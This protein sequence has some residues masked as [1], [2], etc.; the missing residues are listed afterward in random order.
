MDKKLLKIYNELFTSLKS[1]DELAK[2]LKV[3][4]KTIENKVKLSEG[5][6]EHSKKNSG[7]IFKNLLPKYISIK[8]FNEILIKYIANNSLKDSAQYIQKEIIHENEFG[9]LVNTEK[10]SDLVKTLIKLQIAINYNCVLSVSYKGN[11][12][13]VQTKFIKPNQIFVANGSFY[14]YLKYADQNKKDINMPRTFQLNSIDNIQAIEYKKDEIFQTYDEG[15]AYG[16]YNDNTKSVKLIFKGAAAMYLKRERLNSLK[17]EFIEES[18]DNTTL[19]IKLYYNEEVELIKLIQSWMPLV[20]F[21][22]EDE[23]STKIL[24]AIKKNYENILFSSS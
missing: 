19:T 17:W 5:D 7:Y 12:K 3:S 24:T 23:L 16:R 22:K 2:I 10:L 13:A 20:T 4:T 9:E 15:N 8:H 6:I 18:F 21:V 14:L 1:K 11:K